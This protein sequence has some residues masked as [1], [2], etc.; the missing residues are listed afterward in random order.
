[1]S[2]R[3]V[4]TNLIAHDW[5][6]LA[7]FYVEVFGCVRVE[8]RRDLR[9]EWLER[10]S[11]V[12]AARLRGQHLRLPGYDELGARGPTLEIFQYDEVEAQT[13]PVANRAGFGHLAFGVDDVAAVLRAVIAAGGAAHGEVVQ[14]DVAEVGTLTFTYARDPEGNLLELQ[15]WT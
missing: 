9:G 6:R 12:P 14:T 1:M 3:Y 10:G 2:T 13:R 11:G 4:H 5:E 15:A 7:A 8:P